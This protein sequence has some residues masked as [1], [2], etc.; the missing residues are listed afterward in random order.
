MALVVQNGFPVLKL[1]IGNGP[2][3][4]ILNKYVADNVWR[5]FIIERVGH[6]AKLSIREEFVGGQENIETVEKPLTGPYTIFNLDKDKSKLFVGSFPVNYEMQKDIDVNSFEGEIEDLVI[7]NT[8][9]SLWNFVDG[10]EN[11]HG[12]KER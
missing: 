9:V 4:V 1:D 2:D 8:P 5:Q 3:Q 11:N 12:A 10:Y 6:N 7:G